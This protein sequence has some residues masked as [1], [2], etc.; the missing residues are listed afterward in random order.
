MS[1]YAALGKIAV[2]TPEAERFSWSTSFTYQL[3]ALELLT[4]TANLLRCWCA[5]IAERVI[6][7]A[8]D[9]PFNL[10]PEEAMKALGYSALVVGQKN[11]LLSAAPLTLL[12]SIGVNGAD[13]AIPAVGVLR[14]FD[15]A[16]AV[17]G[18][19]G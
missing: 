12:S 10:Q 16:N 4:L 6:R 11:Q 2:N 7:K 13:V 1:V 14:G 17:I 3:A 9:N 15:T 8:S 18:F 5:V 19:A